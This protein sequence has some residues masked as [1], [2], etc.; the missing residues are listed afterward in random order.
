MLRKSR[1][2]SDIAVIGSPIGSGYRTSLRDA[3]EE[4]VTRGG[5]PGKDEGGGRVILGGG[6]EGALFMRSL[7]LNEE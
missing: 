1:S 5:E 6:D 3:T 7:S 2:S 4:T